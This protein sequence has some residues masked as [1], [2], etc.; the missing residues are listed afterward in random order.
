MNKFSY[1]Q[2]GSVQEA[3]EQVNATVS[4]TI[5]PGASED[6]SVLKAGG[7]DLLDLMKEGLS[8]PK[9][10]VSIAHLE[11]FDDM[12]FDKKD[13]L[14]IG[15]NVTL[16][17]IANDATVRNTFFALHQ[18][19]SKAATPQIRNMATM[20]GNLAQRTRCWYFRSKYHDCYRKG[21]VTCFAQ[22][23]Q[24]QYHAIMQ[25]EECA[26]VHSSSL[27]TALLAYDAAV[28]IMG[29][30]GKYKVVELKD[31]FVSPE[32]DRTKENILTAGEIIS[33]VIVPTPKDN[34]KSHYLKMGERESHDWPV[35]DVAV[36]AEM[37]GAKCKK[38]KI[39]LGAAAPVPVLSLAAMD[40][41]KGKNI[42]EGT[43]NQAGIAAMEAATPLSQNAYK[44]TI[45]QALI[46]RALLALLD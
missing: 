38:I 17:R 19:A 37:N 44:V 14:R 7:I 42:E 10:I 45:F 33:A 15:A 12:V 4:E 25:N 8:N 41:V 13:G 1:Y 34:V 43:A 27:S 32:T 29:K 28:E 16:A 21:S 11:G 3:L 20:G 36:V 35:A 9:K 46:N 23:G 40:A 22:G 6:A 5:Q 30:D 31:F 2:A 18:A 39:A 24:N 26:S